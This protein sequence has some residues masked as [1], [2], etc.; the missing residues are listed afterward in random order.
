MGTCPGVFLRT[1]TGDRPAC[2]HFLVNKIKSGFERAHRF[3]IERKERVLSEQA[4][5]I[6]AA[7]VESV[8]IILFQAE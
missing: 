8:S 5:K 6:A 2:M 1:L 3:I 7:E 4:R